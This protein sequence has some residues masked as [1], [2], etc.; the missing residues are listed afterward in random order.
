MVEV[1]MPR[2]GAASP[3]TSCHVF[4]M[5][6]EKLALDEYDVATQSVTSHHVSFA[7]NRIRRLSIPF[8]YVWPAE[9]DLMAQLAGLTLASRWA[10]WQ[11][12]EFTSSSAS[13][14]SVWTKPACNEDR[15]PPATSGRPRRTSPSADST[16]SSC[17]RCRG[18]C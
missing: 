16:C 8:R 18:S 17:R 13:H 2:L 3:D 10:N 7:G 4:E 5:N 14:L 11:R 9:L 15:E 1:M 12:E 6:N